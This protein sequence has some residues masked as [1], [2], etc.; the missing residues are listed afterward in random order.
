MSKSATASIGPGKKLE[1]VALKRAE[2]LL[3]VMETPKGRGVFASKSIPARTILEVSPVL[4]LDPVENENHVRHT[5]LYNYTY[6]WP[7]DPPTQANTQCH[8]SEPFT[9]TQ[10]IVLGLGS[11][12]NHSHINQNVGWE[13]DLANF[14]ITYTTLRDIKEGEELCISYGQRLTFKDTEGETHDDGP[15]DWTDVLNIIDL[16]D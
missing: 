10:A 4:V 16:I 12:F 13:R 11:M 3:L 6:N 15:E 9:M 1:G 5:D 14:L 8:G 2:G 7:Y